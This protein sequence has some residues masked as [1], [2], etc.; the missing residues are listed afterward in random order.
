MFR[1][2]AIAGAARRVIL[3]AVAVPVVCLGADG[4]L[5]FQGAITEP[6]CNMSVA[7]TGISHAELARLASSRMPARIDAGS[8]HV[9][10]NCNASQAVQLSVEGRMSPAHAAG[11]EPGPAVADMVVS[12]VGQDLR[13]GEAIPLALAG[14]KENSIDLETTLRKAADVSNHDTGG[15]MDGA[16]LVSVNYR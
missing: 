9:T 6:V 11:G 5:N 7:H 12:R 2:R 15:R 4:A 10:M 3:I 8:M 16:F 1:N 13:P 14:R